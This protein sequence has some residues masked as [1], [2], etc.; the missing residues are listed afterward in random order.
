MPFTCL[1]SQDE[2]IELASALISRPVNNL[3][4]AHKAGLM[5]LE[6]LAVLPSLGIL[7]SFTEEVKSP[8]G[9][10]NDLDL[11]FILFK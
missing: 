4:I 8:C 1:G 2:R 3:R 11:G 6:V 5:Q 9:P 7:T 10:I